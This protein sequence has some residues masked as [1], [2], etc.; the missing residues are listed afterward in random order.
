MA[1]TQASVVG[2]SDNLAKPS[3]FTVEEIYWGYIIRSGRGPSV[4]VAVAQAVCFFFGV[5]LL[6]AA[7]GLMILP[8]LFFDGGLG[9]MRL[10][11]AALFGAFA[12]YLLWF[13]SRGTQAEVHVDTSIGE[14]REV[15]CNRAGKP[16]TVGAF[17]FDTIGG[18]HLNDREHDNQAVLSLRYRNTSQT[19]MV[20][21][22]TEAQLVS[23]RD[24]LARD[25]MVTPT[26]SDRAA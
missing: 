25:L 23:L 18:I 17:G 10:G 15:I 13:A 3:S 6:T 16:T 14:I 26:T 1:D 11:A 9:P 24:R 12:A 21:E 8:A 22:G 5:C 7:L 20:A 2:F 19:A 4:G